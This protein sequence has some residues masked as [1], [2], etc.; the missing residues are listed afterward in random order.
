[1]NKYEKRSLEAYNKKAIGYDTALEG[2]YT[3]AF[4]TMLLKTV[5]VKPGNNVLD[6]A[7]GN[8]RLLNMFAEKYPINGYG[9]DISDKMIEQARLL[10]PSMRFSIG[11]CER[12][13]YE[14]NAFQVI[15]VCA[16]YHHF[17]HVDCFAR[18]AYR[19]MREG[20]TIYIAEVYYSSFFR[21]IFN[22]FV[23]LMKEGDVK[24]YSPDEIIN[25]LG[26][27]GFRN[28]KLLINDHIQIISACK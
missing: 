12:I 14:D 2:R 26:A 18:E 7:C 11:S 21:T 27:A 8:G 4:K 17:P 5:R 9:I 23:P 6:V 25:T 3:F 24:F 13:P 15:T 22:P 19:L 20:G 10:N 1:M 28:Q 16:A